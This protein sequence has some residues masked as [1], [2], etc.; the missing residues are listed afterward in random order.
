MRRTIATVLAVAV[1]AG[2]AVR[3]VW[4]FVD[5][6][7]LVGAFWVLYAAVFALVAWTNSHVRAEGR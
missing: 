1:A 6:A 5:G 3:A 4:K 2:G 7:P